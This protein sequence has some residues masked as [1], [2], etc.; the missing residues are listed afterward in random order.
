LQENWVLFHTPKDL[1]WAAASKPITS[2]LR[3]DVGAIRAFFERFAIEDGDLAAAP[4][5]QALSFQR[6]HGNRDAWPMGTE[7]QAEE[8]VRERQFLTIDAI[9][10]HEKPARQPFLDLAAAVCKCGRRSLKQE[11][12][13]IPQ[14]GAVQS[15]T[16]LVCVAQ[17]CGADPLA[18]TSS[19]DVR[20]VLCPIISQ[21]DR[22]AS[23]TFPADDADF[24]ALIAR[25]VGNNGSETSLNEID[26]IDLSFADLQ[27][28]SDGK[29]DGLEAGL[30]QCVICAR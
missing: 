8:L 24:D 22:E 11:C 3:R 13:H 16:L 27:S 23:H 28:L 26:V 1:V 4:C 29:F 21:H 17:V 7:H 15:G 20:R 2:A 5:N 30:E 12:V 25:A 14:L 6:L 19:L 9:I 18:S 10:R